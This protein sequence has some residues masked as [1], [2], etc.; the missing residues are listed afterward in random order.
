MRVNAL[1]ESLDLR[2]EHLR[3]ILTRL[4]EEELI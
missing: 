1:S 4:R 2:E 3:K